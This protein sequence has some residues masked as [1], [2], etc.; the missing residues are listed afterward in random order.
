MG[1][2]PA[3]QCPSASESQ[4]PEFA[5]FAEHLVRGKYA[6][7]FPLVDVRVQLLLD[8][9]LDGAAQFLVFVSE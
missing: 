8:E 9:A 5:E 2:P 1:T 3:R 6:R 7:F 4:Q